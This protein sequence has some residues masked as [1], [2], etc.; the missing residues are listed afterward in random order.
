MRHRRP[1]NALRQLLF[2]GAAA[3][4][5]ASHGMMSFPTPRNA[6]DRQ[7]APWNG[8]VPAFPIPFDSPNWCATPDA[9][10]AD[11]RKIS[12]GGGQACFWFNNGEHGCGSFFF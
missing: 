6:L 3:R 2:L 7:L 9:A 8:T 4:E 1:V 12:G 5:T 10:S 11:P